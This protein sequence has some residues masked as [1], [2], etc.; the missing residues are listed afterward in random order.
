M[1]KLELDYDR[2]FS[3]YIRHRDCPDGRGYCITCGAPITPKTCDCGHYIGRAHKATRWDEIN[4][5]AQCKNC[6]ERLEGLIPVY[7]KVLI[8]LYG[9]PTVEELERK[10]RTV[11]KLS[12][13]EMLDRINYYK[14][15]VK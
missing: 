4:C 6:N 15:M 1:T 12:R 8:R 3:L 5:H 10:K 14:S 13:S 11:F 2:Y 7:R 9:L